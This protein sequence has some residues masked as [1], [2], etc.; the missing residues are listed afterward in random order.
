MS[1]AFSFG[2]A[3][4][5]AGQKRFGVLPIGSLADGTPGR[6]RSWSSTARGRASGP[7]PRQECTARLRI[8]GHALRE[9]D[10]WWR[11][12]AGH[13]AIP[14]TFSLNARKPA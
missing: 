11:L 4:A 2:T 12:P 14:L 6:S 5:E 1:A 9:S 10:V 8:V 3:R 13:P 7:S